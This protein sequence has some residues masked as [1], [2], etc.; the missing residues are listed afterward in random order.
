VLDRVTIRVAD[1]QASERF[2]RPVLGV[3]GVEP[4]R[5][6]RAETEWDDFVVAPADAACPPTRGLHVG[7]VA[8]SRQHVDEF[9]LVG[10]AGGCED[11]GP[12]GE[13]P[14][15]TPG[16]YGAFLRDPD[17][18]SVEAVHH[19]DVRRGGHV[20]HLWIGVRDLDTA[21]AFYATVMRFTG[22]REGR[23][24]EAGRQF[25]GAWATF[26]LVADGRP[27]TEH[28]RLA[29]PAPDRE[30]VDGFYAATSGAGYG[31]ERL[32]EQ[33]SSS[34]PYAAA[35]F[36]PDGTRVESVYRGP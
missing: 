10:T 24:W 27:V 3:L 15:Y 28:L 16:Y 19:P 32:G 14:L 1:H 13:R 18:N 26:S 9:W 23:R 2:Y 12:P 17:G 30:T 4:S 21:V 33:A 5:S 35:A 8:P 6:D 34:S 29:F 22:L 25:R 7:F 31:G 20:D 36:D 11:D